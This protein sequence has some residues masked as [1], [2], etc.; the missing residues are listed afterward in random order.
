MIDNIHTFS[1]KYM[2]QTFVTH[3]YF[4]NSSA[5]AFAEAAVQ[6]CS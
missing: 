3:I 1:V 4:D 2:F 6:M 5:N